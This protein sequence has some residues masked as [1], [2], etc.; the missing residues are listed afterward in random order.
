MMKNQIVLLCWD[1]VLVLQGANV[2]KNYYKEEDYILNIII[3]LC[4]LV[5]NQLNFAYVNNRQ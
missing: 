1:I 4:V 5:I 3:I 2:V